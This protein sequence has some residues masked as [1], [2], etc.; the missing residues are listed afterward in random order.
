MWLILLLHML[1]AS[2]FTL[3][4]IVL[5]FMQPILLIGVRMIIGGA[6]LLG[7]QYFFNREH[8]RFD[9]KH[10]GLFVQIVLFHIYITYICEF[11]SLQYVTSAKACLLFSLTPF[12][13]ALF[14]YFLLAERLTK[15]QWIGLLIG[16]AGFWPVMGTFVPTENIFGTYSI[17]SLPEI[18]LLISVVCASYGW[19]L[20]KKLVVDYKYSPMMVNGL[21]MFCG[22]ICA[23]FTSFLV[24][25]KPA[26]TI[27]SGLYLAKYMPPFNAAFLTFAGYCLLLIFVASIICYNLYG[28]LLRVYSATFISFAG[29]TTPIFAAFFGWIFLSETVSW[30]F[31]LTLVIVTG[32]LYL[33]YQDE[34][35]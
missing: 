16:F 30:H 21:G 2:T 25:G 34:L 15:R 23:L 5:E 31:V 24:E 19:I 1:F 11:W 32:G 28:Y 14:S 6:I 8:W 3:G 20:L 35:N 18:V 27:P 13:T 7:Y 12:V 33:F 9:L 4:K 26:L 17:I 10:I 22:G 29:F